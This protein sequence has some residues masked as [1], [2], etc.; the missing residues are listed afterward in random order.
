[1]GGSKRVLVPEP[2][3][4]TG[5]RTGRW[6]LASIGEGR[7][8]GVVRTKKRMDYRQLKELMHPED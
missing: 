1:M 6:L 4:L 2:K 3:G 8:M 5:P 7:K